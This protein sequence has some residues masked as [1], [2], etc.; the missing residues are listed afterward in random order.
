MWT[1]ADKVFPI[2]PSRHHEHQA[3]YHTHT[4]YLALK[5]CFGL[6]PVSYLQLSRA[7]QFISLLI[8]SKILQHASVKMFTYL[9]CTH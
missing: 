2:Q 8:T 4:R 1:P 6:N 7:R 5:V 3:I 9:L